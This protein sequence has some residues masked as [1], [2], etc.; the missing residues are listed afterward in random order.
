MRIRADLV[1]RLN[2]SRVIVL[3]IP[4]ASPAPAPYRSRPPLLPENP[5]LSAA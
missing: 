5:L 1:H 4:P 3:N 2:F